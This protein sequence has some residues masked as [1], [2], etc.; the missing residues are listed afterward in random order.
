MQGIQ[1]A[2]HQGIDMIHQSLIPATVPDFSLDPN[3]MI[4]G[5]RDLPARSPSRFSDLNFS[6]SSIDFSKDTVESYLHRPVS[7]TR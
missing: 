1:F 6:L 7:P 3:A 5:S 2:V 4:S